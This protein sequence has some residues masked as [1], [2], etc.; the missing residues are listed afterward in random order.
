MNVAR[1]VSCV[2]TCLA[3]TLF[4]TPSRAQQPTPNYTVKRIPDSSNP[5]QPPAG[6]A[7]V[8]LV[9]NMASVGPGT[10]KVNI[11]LDGAWI[12]A[13]D[14]ETHI[15]FAVDPGVHHLCAAYQSH[16]ED[17]D[18]EGRILLLRLDAKA[19]H[20]YYLRYHAL[21]ANGTAIA[22]FEK[23]DDDEGQHLVQNTDSA[24]FTLKK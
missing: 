17:M 8:Y 1:L 11:G 21:L 20:I 12:G 6:K 15:R 13:T 9:E 24:V 7:L 10:K 3:L 16:F 5:A 23:V 2:S 4:T 14:A 18:A 19:G 22:F